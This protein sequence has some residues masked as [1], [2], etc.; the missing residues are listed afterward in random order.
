MLQI[1]RYVQTLQDV[2]LRTGL[3]WAA[4]GNQ[5]I[6][7][8]EFSQ[9]SVLFGRLSGY[10]DVYRILMCVSN[11]KLML[12]GLYCLWSMN[13]NAVVVPVYCCLWLSCT[14]ITHAIVHLLAA[15]GH[16][17]INALAHYWHMC[18]HMLPYTVKWSSC[19]FLELFK[20]E[21]DLLPWSVP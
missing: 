9:P 13:G 1:V 11:A 10:T 18:R 12:E 8:P 19:A 16:Q 5:L 20:F 21:P 7:I 14:H 2:L 17:M 15:L 3:V 4:V 6:R